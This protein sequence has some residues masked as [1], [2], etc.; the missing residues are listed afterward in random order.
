MVSTASNDTESHRFFNDILL[1]SSLLAAEYTALQ[2]RLSICRNSDKPSMCAKT[3]PLY[4]ISTLHNPPVSILGQQGGGL[5]ATRAR[6]SVPR[7]ESQGFGHLALRANE[8]AVLLFALSSRR[9]LRIS[10]HPSR[11]VLRTLLRMRWFVSKQWVT[12]PHA[13]EP[14]KP[15]SRSMGREQLCRGL[16]R[17]REGPAQREGEGGLLALCSPALGHPRCTEP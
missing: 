2:P 5:M 15:A 11:R 1:G 16:Q 10:A 6:G 17:E 7:Y 13:E 3:E 4:V 12:R 9:P 14:A 8:K